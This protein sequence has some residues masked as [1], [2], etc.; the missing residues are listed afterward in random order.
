MTILVQG[1]IA[2]GLVAPT[3]EKKQEKAKKKNEKD[4]KTTHFCGMHGCY[5]TRPISKV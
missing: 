2:S 1:T 5:E 3:V 4:R